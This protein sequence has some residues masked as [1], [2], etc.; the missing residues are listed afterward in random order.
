MSAFLQENA[1]MIQI[2][3]DGH[4]AVVRECFPET[5]CLAVGVDI[6]DDYHRPLITAINHLLE[7][8]FHPRPIRASYEE[9][10]S[11]AFFWHLVAVKTKPHGFCLLACRLYI[12]PHVVLLRVDFKKVFSLHVIGQTEIELAEFSLR[13][14]LALHRHLQIVV[15]VVRIV[16]VDDISQ[17]S[18]IVGRLHTESPIV[19]YP[20]QPD[21]RS[22]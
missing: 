4:T 22:F 12:F 8:S 10:L 9:C 19:A 18:V 2:V 13:N 5:P 16:L 6:V 14:P 20:F 11:L 15:F 1:A 7:Q 21:Y 3:R 17:E